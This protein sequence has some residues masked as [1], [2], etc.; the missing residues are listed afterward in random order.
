MESGIVIITK[1]VQEK[2]SPWLLFSSPFSWRLWCTI[3][4][5]FFTIGLLLCYMEREN[6][7][8]FTEGNISYRFGSILWFMMGALILF[9]R[10]DLKNGSSRVL[11]MCWILFAV[12][13][14][15]SYTASLSAFLTADN[16]SSSNIDILSLQDKG[17]GTGIGIRRGS[18]VKDFLKQR[19]G[20][21]RIPL[22]EMR[23]NSEFEHNLTSGKVI[24]IVDEIPYASILLSDLSSSTCDFGIV[25]PSLTE[26]GFGFGFNKK[27]GLVKALSIA[28]MNLT[29]SGCLQ[30]IQRKYRLDVNIPCSQD[31]N[32]SI[33][34]VGLRNSLS[35]F[36]PMLA[37]LGLCI[38]AHCIKVY[39]RKRTLTGPIRSIND[40]SSVHINASFNMR[41]RYNQSQVIDLE[42]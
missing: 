39:R 8:E 29:E 37:F 16:L 10:E 9:E 36:F 17:N 33:D 22:V 4:G 34:K 21:L 30:K 31:N 25:R 28:L 7:P 40:D 15:S 23:T 13:V 26:Q 14:G 35:V 12:L 19:F 3:V 2:Q 32:I 38:S 11:V 6:H 27:R 24:A 1:V 20:A 41:R 42:P 18:I 5:T